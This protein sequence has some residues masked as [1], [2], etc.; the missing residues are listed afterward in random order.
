MR[1]VVDS[2]YSE[3]ESVINQALSF[4]ESHTD[5]MDV[6]HKVMLLT[7]EAV[8]NGMKHGNKLDENKSVY[9][10]FMCSD[11]SIEVWVEDEGDGFDREAI[12][13]LVNYDTAVDWPAR[14]EREGPF[15]LR[16]LADAPKRRVID[17][18]SGT[19]EHARWLADQGFTVV[20][21]EGVRE[22][23]E[24]ARLGAPA[25]VEHL[26]GDLGA[27]EAMVRGQFGA[28]LCLGNTLPSLLG[29]ESLS[30]MLIG[31]RRHLLP[32]SPFV[33]HLFNYDRLFARGER[34]LPPRFLSSGKGELVFLRLLELRDDGVVGITE[35]VLDHLP[36]RRDS[37]IEVLHTRHLFQQGWRYQE[38]LTV[39]DV[40]RF[41]TV[42]AFGSFAGE[43]FEP[44]TS[45]E[46]VLVAK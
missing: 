37:P 17:L 12:P 35:T 14:L 10:D 38:L 44:M 1:L 33:V 40:A 5:N 39:L 4:F 3:L 27:V 42:E 43:P 6:L 7:S 19:G 28:A 18:G 25:G 46:L 15:L 23:W 32:G 13:A 34:L 22:R 21:I 16:A 8:T 20:G 30:R 36:S 24:V 41:N 45:E 26:L 29:P 11:H 9:V 31:L 2:S